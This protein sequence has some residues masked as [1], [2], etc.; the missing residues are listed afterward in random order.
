MAC[1]S[2]YLATHLGSN[3]VTALAGLD[4]DDLTHF[5]SGIS[6]M[7]LRMRTRKSIEGEVSQNDKDGTHN[8]RGQWL[9]DTGAVSGNFEILA[10]L[11]SQQSTD[12]DFNLRENGEN[13]VKIKRI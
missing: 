2:R 5:D 4:V 9:L 6:G 8:G 12:T 7:K 10:Q 3:L 11:H 1:S 13:A